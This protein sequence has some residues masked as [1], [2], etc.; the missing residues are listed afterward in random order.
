MRLI[1]VFLPDLSESLLPRLRH[2]FAHAQ[3]I[4]HFLRPFP[5]VLARA[6]PKRELA[7]RGYLLSLGERVN[8]HFMDFYVP[9]HFQSRDTSR[10]GPIRPDVGL[11]R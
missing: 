8:N 10:T 1:I 9:P 6:L 2:S 11:P 5:A 7:R 3:S 4:A